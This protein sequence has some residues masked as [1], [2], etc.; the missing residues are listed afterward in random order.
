MNQETIESY[1]KAGRITSE[2]LRYAKSITKPGIP[3]LEISEKIEAK[4]KSLGGVLAF[5]INLSMDEVAAHFIPLDNKIL[6]SG[7]LKIDIGTY[8]NNC[9][10]DAAI[11]LDLTPEKKYTKLIEASKE[12]LENAIKI[13]KTGMEVRR[14]GKEIQE[15]ITK[16]GFSPVIDLSGHQLQNGILHSGLSIPNYDNLDKRKL[17]DSMVIAIEPF[18]TTGIGKIEDGKP[19]GIYR[20][21][22]KKPQRIEKAKKILNFIEEN[23]QFRPFSK[24]WIEKEFGNSSLYLSMLESQNCLYQYPQLIESSKSPVSQAEHTILIKDKIVITR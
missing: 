13:V 17:E 9:I 1:K 18:A 23:Y 20:L 5:P 11:S 10:A 16:Y 3:L 6:A 22:E 15:T 4:I 24:L 2:A 14:I 12:A 8:V 7:L 21:I 19:S